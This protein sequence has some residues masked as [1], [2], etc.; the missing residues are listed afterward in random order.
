MVQATQ[1]GKKRRNLLLF[2]I[3]PSRPPP[4][5]LFP[6]EKM[7]PPFVG[8]PWW[9]TGIR[10]KPLLHTPPRAEKAPG[11]PTPSGTWGGCLPRGEASVTDSRLVFALARLV[12]G[13][14]SGNCDARRFGSWLW[15]LAAAIPVQAMSRDGHDGGAHT[16]PRGHLK[17]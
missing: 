11:E 6:V 15:P 4:R 3:T 1:H 7:L 8:S 9:L 5:P 16:R 12:N 10:V 2:S 14:A 13:L 17:C